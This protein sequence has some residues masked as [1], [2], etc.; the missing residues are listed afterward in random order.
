MKLINKLIGAIALTMIIQSAQSSTDNKAI[1]IINQTMLA[2]YYAADDFRA[3]ARMVI[4]DSSGNKQI[5][6]FTILRK[7]KKD[8]ENQDM[9]VFFSRPSDVKN[10]VFRVEKNTHGDDNR[11]LYMPALD[12]VKRISAGD[13]RTS[14][15]GTH[16]FYEDVSGRNPKEDDF[17]LLETN[18]KNYIIKAVPKDKSTVEFS[19]YIV[20]VNVNNYLPMK[21]TYYNPQGKA[22]REMEVIKTKNIQ[23]HETIVHS[24]VTLLSDNSYT[25]LKLRRVNYNIGLPQKIFSDRSLRTPPK[26][27]LK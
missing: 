15:V 20:N 12:L 25:E 18:D 19:Y 6:Q 10:T 27:W 1:D 3:Q 2:S 7:D 14:F 22:T 9:L 26:K 5:R 13:K 11:W 17:K 8:L 24:T 23:G 4:V 16:F 21:V